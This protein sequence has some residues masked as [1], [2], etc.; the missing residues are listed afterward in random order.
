MKRD[1]RDRP[2]RVSDLT[3]ALG[4]RAPYDYAEEWDNVGLLAGNSSD[5]VTGVVTAINLGPEALEAAK[6]SGANVVV[7][8]HPPIF[9][10]VSRITAASSP[11]LYESVRRGLSVVALHT[12][13]DLASEALSRELSGRL[14]LQ[15]KGFLAPR[16]GGETPRSLRLGKLITYVPSTALDRVRL[17]VCAAG[18]GTI[19]NYTECSFSWAGEGTFCGGEGSSPAVGK[20]GRLEKVE[21]RRLEIVFPWKILDEVVAA[22]RRAHPYEEM[23]YDVLRLEQ[24]SAAGIGYG[25]LSSPDQ[26]TKLVFKKLLESV[27]DAF[28]LRTVNVSGPG[29]SDP[30]M[31]VKSVAFSP[32]SGSSFIGAASAK[33]ADVYVCGEAGYHQM[34]DARS[35]GLTLVTLGHSYSERFFVETV[36]EWCESILPRASGRVEKVFEAIHDV[37]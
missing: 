27:K 17:A 1:T 3:G 32:G 12:N 21:E 9:K 16:G 7:C 20:A 25:F 36:S 14:G 5:A 29:L 13:F 18:A 22:A 30:G 28:K 8:H 24:P 26:S 34:L 23:A 11:Y 4:R 10:P 31:R 19:G 37:V 33:G 35:K 2:V 6:K 15:F